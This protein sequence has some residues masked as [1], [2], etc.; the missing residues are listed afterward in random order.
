MAPSRAPPKAANLALPS[1]EPLPSSLRLP[2]THP[3]VLK[4]LSPLSRP[5]L[6]KLA[7]EW[8][9]PEHLPTCGP[10]INL[11]DSP[12]D[13][14]NPW[15]AAASIDELRDLYRELSSRRGS[16]RELLDRVL[17]GD[18]RA[19]V[20]LQQL[21]M[22]DAAQLAEH[23]SSRRWIAYAISHPSSAET[24]TQTPARVH[25]SAF[26]LAL[27]GEI[28]P[29]AKAHYHVSR[30]AALP[31]TLIRL[32]LFSTPYSPSS[33]KVA[34]ATDA[35]LLSA[36]PRTILL[37][38][39]DAAPFVYASF[40]AAAPPSTRRSTSENATHASPE[41]AATIDAF[42]LAALPLALSRPGRPRCS[43]TPAALPARALGATP[44]RP[45]A[46]PPAAAAGASTLI[47]GPECLPA[48]LDFAQRGGAGEAV[49][50]AGAESDDGEDGEDGEGDGEGGDGGRRR[51]RRRCAVAG[52]A[53]KESGT[54]RTRRAAAAAAKRGFEHAD[55]T[56]SL[57]AAKRRALRRAAAARFGTAGAPAPGRPG[58]WRRR[59]KRGWTACRCGCSTAS[60]PTPR[61]AAW[62]GG[63][64]T[65]A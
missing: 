63:G 55:P 40:P 43:V 60:P 58:R 51:R 59:P 14:E 8:C 19:G 16:K 12:D 25:P 27:H 30:P 11:D 5:V 29:L 41:T 23:P 10:Y 35:S 61:T 57:P 32:C 47:A 37:A 3:T 48:A 42:V 6:L 53:G 13:P 49:R 4:T 36:P 65:C 39:P 56:A 46:A 1:F 50:R 54:G 44:P 15:S 9:S 52:A 2:S 21:A 7:A 62:A 26:L 33:S 28:A 31:L 38:F 64:S 20:S 22:A 18:W 45:G 17:E 34:A 24:S